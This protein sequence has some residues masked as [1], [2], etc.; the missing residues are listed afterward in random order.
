MNILRDKNFR[1][2]VVRFLFV[3]SFCY[4]FT[5]AIIGL[6]APNGYYVSFVAKYLDYVTLITKSLLKGTELLL[7]IFNIHTYRAP[8]FI[9]RIV[10]GRGVQIAY[11]CVG[12][13]VMS[14]WIAFV[15]VSAGS[16]RKKSLSLVSGLFLLWLINVSRISLFLVA[17]NRNW[18][19][20]FGLDHHTLFNI[21]AYFAIFLMIFFFV[22]K[23]NNIHEKNEYPGNRKQD[24]TGIQENEINS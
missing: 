1:T 11:D 14:F 2:F 10:G 9:I 15:T 22:R 5:L 7:S 23:K 4:F 24:G 17:I 12:Y 18:P 16:F 6:S 8:G 21:T 19:M 20:P 13:G 3:F